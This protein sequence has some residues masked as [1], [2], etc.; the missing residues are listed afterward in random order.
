MDK[1]RLQKL[2]GVQLDEQPEDYHQRLRNIAAMVT[3][4]MIEQLNT[5]NTE[6]G[7]RTD[8]LKN[9]DEIATQYFNRELRARQ[10]R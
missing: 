10:R 3:D 5:G 2:A 1:K 6:E 8:T 7:A 9:I 4:L